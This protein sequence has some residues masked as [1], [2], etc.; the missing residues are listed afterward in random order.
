MGNVI[1][2]LI[3]LAIVAAASSKLIIDKR[4]GVKCSGCPHAP[5]GGFKK[6]NAQGCG[7]HV[8]NIVEIK[9]RL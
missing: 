8:D 3:I 2:I 5:K 9:N 4:N 7:C 6:N 1:V